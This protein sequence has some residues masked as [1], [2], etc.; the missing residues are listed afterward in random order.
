MSPLSYYSSRHSSSGAVNTVSS[1]SSIASAYTSSEPTSPMA[2]SPAQMKQSSSF[3]S[4]SE[5][6][7]WE[8]LS[9][10]RHGDDWIFGGLSITNSV[11]HLFHK[12]ES[13]GKWRA[14]EHNYI[15]SNV[16]CTRTDYPGR[17]HP[18]QNGCGVGWIP[19]DCH[20][21]RY[22]SSGFEI[23]FIFGF[24]LNATQGTQRYEPTG[25]SRK[26]HL[27]FFDH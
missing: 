20:L 13:S 7:E 6:S 8:R 11:K 17:R 2:S 4:S 16:V 23:A 12:K 14:A 5:R 3:S 27:A 1:Y 21:P 19:K 25:W 18:S 26:V 22:C 24:C 15:T 10:G 9:Y